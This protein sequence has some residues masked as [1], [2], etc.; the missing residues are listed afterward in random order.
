MKFIPHFFNLSGM[1]PS[2]AVT[3][4]RT[5]DGQCGTAHSEPISISPDAMWPAL[6]GVYTPAE[7]PAS[8]NDICFFRVDYGN[9]DADQIVFHTGGKRS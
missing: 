3:C 2:R 8:S 5:V 1:D 7:R 6:A 4:W 9:P